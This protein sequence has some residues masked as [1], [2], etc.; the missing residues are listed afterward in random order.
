MLD[1]VAGHIPDGPAPGAPPR[2]RRCVADVLHPASKAAT[3]ILL[4][5]RSNCTAEANA[6]LADMARNL[7]EIGVRLAPGLDRGAA[8]ALGNLI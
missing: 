5:T 4:S 2:R 7:G 8:V 6:R 3:A 1:E